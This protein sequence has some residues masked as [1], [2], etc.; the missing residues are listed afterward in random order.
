MSKTAS[1]TVKQ[2]EKQSAIAALLMQMFCHSEDVTAIVNKTSMT[3]SS[4]VKQVENNQQLKDG[5]KHCKTG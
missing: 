1:I 2:V 5:I 4:T 3:V